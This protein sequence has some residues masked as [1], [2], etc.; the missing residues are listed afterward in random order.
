MGKPLNL[1]NVWTDGSY[2]HSYEVGGAGWLIRHGEDAD[3]E[4]WRVLKNFPNDAKAHGSDAAEI[5]GVG[6]ALQD[7]PNGS[8]VKLRLDCQNVI[9]WLN[10]KKITSKS[11]VQVRF[12]GDIFAYAMQGVARMESVE[13]IKVG[14]NS[15]ADLKR[16]N[17]LA[18]GASHFA[19]TGKLSR[20]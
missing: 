7:I 12:L 8:T 16:V 5:F 9:D 13:F 20:K 17:E 4:G 11:I 10:A 3:R 19:R 1:Y 2:N 15:N 18:R 6:C 14:G